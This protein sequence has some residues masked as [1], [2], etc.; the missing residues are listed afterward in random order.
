M[1]H[2]VNGEQ[3]TKQPILQVLERIAYSPDGVHW[4]LSKTDT[5]LQFDFV[6][7]VSAIPSLEVPATEMA[8]NEV[9]Y[10]LAKLGLA[11]GFLIHIGRQE[12]SQ[13]WNNERFYD[14]SMRDSPYIGDISRFTLGKV[15]Q[16]DCV[17]FDT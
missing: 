7:T 17:W 3:P 9:I 12:Q 16:I 15:E 1:P 10:R 2:L 14:L 5:Q 4:V 11:A 13:N 8:H 6:S